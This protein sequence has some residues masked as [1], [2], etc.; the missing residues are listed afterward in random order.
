[1]KK[2]A[3]PTPSSNDESQKRF[4]MA[5]KENLEIIMGQRSQKI[6]EL[7]PGASQ[8]EIISKINEILRLLQ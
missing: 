7:Q 5:I 8:D 3:I 6:T 4:D 2:R 1:M